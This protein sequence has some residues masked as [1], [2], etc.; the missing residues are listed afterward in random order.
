MNIRIVSG[1]TDETW[2]A[3]TKRQK[4]E[5]E[6]GKAVSE[7]NSDVMDEGQTIRRHRSF[8]DL[9]D[10]VAEM[11][12]DDDLIDDG[13]L[14][15]GGAP[16]VDTGGLDALMSHQIGKQSYVVVFVKEILCKAMAKGMRID[17][18]RVKSVAHSE[19]LQL[20]RDASRGNTVT[21][22]VKEQ[23]AGGTVLV[24]EPV[25]GLFAEFGREEQ[26]PHFT[27][28]GVD[29]EIAGMDVLDFD[30]H[31]FADTCTCGSKET[32]NEVPLHVSFLVQTILEEKIIG[33]AD[34][35]LKI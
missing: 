27:P 30:L 9:C 13:L 7:F 29:V 20:L 25:G 8:L 6:N 3:F 17:H 24:I 18:F 11:L 1:T 16:E 35:I 15:G 31:Q 28:F 33:I 22:A 4:Y 2:A 26:P 19:V 32:H 5:E 34:D 23:V 10:S 14:F 21:E 12:P